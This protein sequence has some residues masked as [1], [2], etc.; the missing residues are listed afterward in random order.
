MYVTR[1]CGL[2]LS[3]YRIV[4]PL[5]P[6]KIGDKTPLW[7]EEVKWMTS[8]LWRSIRLLLTSWQHL[9]H[10]QLKPWKRDLGVGGGGIIAI[11]LGADPRKHW[12][13]VRKETGDGRKPIK[14]A[15]SRQFQL[16][17]W[18]LVLLGTP[19]GWYRP[20]LS[21]ISPAK[22]QRGWHIYL[23]T[24]HPSLVEI[25]LWRKQF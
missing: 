12:Q 18:S 22:G 21:I 24:P 16:G 25:G 6:V 13:G 1:E 9:D 23:P 14:S 7:S 11:Y 19:E 10:R 20:Q 2:S 3:E 17:N 4:L 15:F 8:A 5:L